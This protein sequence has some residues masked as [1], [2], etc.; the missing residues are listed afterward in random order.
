MVLHGYLGISWGS[1]L[2]VPRIGS[3]LNGHSLGNSLLL[4]S[5]TRVLKYHHLITHKHKNT[6]EW[7]LHT[8]PRGRKRE[9][10]RKKTLPPLFP[11]T[12][13]LPV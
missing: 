10:K 6:L 3:H 9:R 2:G 7:L 1:S 11:L 5:Y 13:P 4:G 12:F 8:F